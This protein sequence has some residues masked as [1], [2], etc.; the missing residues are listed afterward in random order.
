MEAGHKDVGVVL[1]KHLN[2]TKPAT[3]VSHI[4]ANHVTHISSLVVSEV[5][6]LA[7]GEARQKT[8]MYC[9]LISNV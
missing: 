9:V 3:P 5:F 8:I 6:S 2:F 1:Y 7:M 4:S